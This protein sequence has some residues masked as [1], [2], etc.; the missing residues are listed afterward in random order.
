MDTS[1]MYKIYLIKV[2]MCVAIFF[3][4]LLPLLDAGRMICF[5]LDNDN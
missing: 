5:A 3:L 1:P 2:R 4:E